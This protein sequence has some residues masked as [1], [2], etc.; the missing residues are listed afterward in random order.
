MAIIVTS[1]A[2]LYVP[3]LKRYPVQHRTEFWLVAAPMSALAGWLTV[4]AAINGLTVMTGV[5]LIDAASAPAWAAGGIVLVVAV[6][7][8][9]ALAS[10][11]WLYPI[12][13][14]W[15]LLAVYVAERMDK[16]M[17]SLLAAVG[18]LLLMIAV[19]WVG[20]HRAILL[21]LPRQQ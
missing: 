13:A 6:G 9:L 18:A 3:L 1:A 5:G 11:N 15:G 21:P 16:P 2:V 8:V 10:K 7:G 14:A 20:T 12:P 17:I 19:A 4:A